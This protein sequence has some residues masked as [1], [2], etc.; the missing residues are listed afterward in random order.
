MT[1]GAGGALDDLLQQCCTNV[2]L[3]WYCVITGALSDLLTYREHRPTHLKVCS[4][5]ITGR[6][7]LIIQE[8]TCI[9]CSLH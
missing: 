1:V 7:I 6:D 5:L 4:K 3:H 9:Y 8:F 2:V